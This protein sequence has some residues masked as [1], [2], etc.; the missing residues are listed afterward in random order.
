VISPRTHA[1]RFRIWQYCQTCEWNATVAEIAEA[2]GETSRRIGTVVSDAGWIN[3]LRTARLDYT[4][5]LKSSYAPGGL[6]GVLY[7]DLGF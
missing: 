1:L 2:L 7:T 5:H 3:R 6:P 4:P